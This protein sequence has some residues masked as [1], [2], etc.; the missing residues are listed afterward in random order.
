MNLPTQ[1]VMQHAYEI[2]ARQPNAPSSP[3]DVNDSGGVSF[4]AAAAIAAAGI[5]IFGNSAER[6]RFVTA[7]AESGSS[8]E[9]FTV[10]RRFGWDTQFC[11]STV[12][13]NDTFLSH[14]RRGRV[15]D[16]L[17]GP[18]EQHRS[19]FGK[20]RRGDGQNRHDR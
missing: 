18:A 5:E 13:R 4:C 20:R 10:F 7:I 8:G 3:G 15:L 14:E 17:S 11:A 12:G 1:Q 16:L 2:Y 6:E 9:I 19:T